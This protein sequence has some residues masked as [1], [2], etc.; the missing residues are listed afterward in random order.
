M[1]GVKEIE[2]SRVESTLVIL[3]LKVAFFCLCCILI[4][5]GGAAQAQDSF[6]YGP[7]YADELCIK[8]GTSWSPP[9]D[10]SWKELLIEMALNSEGRIDS[11]KLLTSSG[12]PDIDEEA[13][14][15]LR[16]AEPYEKLPEKEVSAIFNLHFESTP[17]MRRRRRHAHQCRYKEMPEKTIVSDIRPEPELPKV[18]TPKEFASLVQRRIKRNWLPPKSLTSYDV[19]TRFDIN[20][21]GEVANLR[22]V[23]SSG[24]LGADAA[25]IAAISSLSPL[26]QRPIGSEGEEIHYD[27]FVFSFTP[28]PTPEIGSEKEGHAWKIKVFSSRI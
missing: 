10:M 14:R 7:S 8:I 4:V 6:G 18:L 25:A 12:L 22:V 24:D 9:E 15:L 13:M 21:A 3:V 16:R 20:R 26:V 27:R 23:S 17:A 2:K 28:Q 1:S 19:V 11:L 5:S